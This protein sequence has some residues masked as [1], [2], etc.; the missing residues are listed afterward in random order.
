[1]K[2]LSY[3]HCVSVSGGW[4]TRR[5]SSGGQMNRSRPRHQSDKARTCTTLTGFLTAGGG[6]SGLAGAASRKAGL[7]GG[8]AISGASLLWLQKGC[9]K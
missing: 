4:W 1:M 3:D 5:Q 9:N 6:V 2:E 8:L 7:I